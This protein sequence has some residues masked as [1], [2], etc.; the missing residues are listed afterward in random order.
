MEA[1]SFAGF[2]ILVLEDDVLLRKHLTAYLE[3]LGMDVTGAGSMEAARR[4]A[5]DLAFDYALVDVN[6]PDG[7]GTDL[8][9]EQAFSSHTGV[10]VVTAEGGITG[11]VEA[12]RLGALDY[13]VKPFDPGEVPLVIQRARR[14]RQAARLDEFRRTGEA[15]DELLFGPALAGVER[16]LERILAADVR[17]QTGLAPVLVLG[18]TG[19]GKTSIARWLHRRGPRADQSMVEVNCS[20][21]PETLAESELFGHER[22]AFTDAH[23]ARIGLF[24]AAHGGTLF[25]DELPSLGLALQAKVLT[26][27]EDRTVRRVGGNRSLRIDVRVIAASNQDLMTLV[28]EK[29]FRE[30]LYHRLDLYRVELPPLRERGQDILDLGERFV[31]RLCRRHGIPRRRISAVGRARLLAWPWPGNIRELAHEVERAIVFADGDEMDFEP[32]QRHGGLEAETMP[33]TEGRAGVLPGDWFDERFVFPDEGFRL[34]DA[35]GR[36]VQHALKQSN[37]NVSAAA[38]LLGVSR[39]VVRYRL[40]NRRAASGPG[41]PGSGCGPD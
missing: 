29:R 7:R 19:T 23:S 20:A 35:M 8:L 11:A 12:M 39:D 28:H 5:A 36:L 31:E 14:Q 26:A 22:G 9:R 4:F 15:R 2:S 17:L 10:V 3:S 21:L 25:L 41:A 6:L 33:G 38:R 34:E 32:L 1:E 40:E 16:Q 18:E 24:E 30:D 37:G 13:L 27:V